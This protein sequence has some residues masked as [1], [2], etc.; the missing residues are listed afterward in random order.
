[1]D[2][3]PPIGTPA[4]SARKA[5]ISESSDPLGQ[6]DRAG[7][8][9]HVVDLDGLLDELAGGHRL[10]HRAGGQV[11][12]TA[13]G[14]GHHELQGLRRVPHLPPAVDPP[15]VSFSQPAAEA[16]SS[17]VAAAAANIRPDRRAS[18]AGASLFVTGASLLRM[19]F[20]GCSN[21]TSRVV[22]VAVTVVVVVFLV[23]AAASTV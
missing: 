1:M 4:G 8:A 22:T 10:L 14:G 18:G 23:P 13:R 16:A 11:P 2:E 5:L 21:D 7:R 20:A 19:C 15:A 3:P 17:T 6:A 12:P 9:G